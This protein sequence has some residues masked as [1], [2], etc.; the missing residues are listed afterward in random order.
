MVLEFFCPPPPINGGNG[1]GLFAL[2]AV[3]TYVTTTNIYAYSSNTVTLGSNFLTIN[4]SPSGAAGNAQLAVFCLLRGISNIYMYSSNSVSYG[5]NFSNSL[6]GTATGN[7]LL[8]I[9]LGY[10]A[11]PSAASYQI[12]TYSNNATSVTNTN[13]PYYQGTAS[14]GTS[15]FGLFNMGGWSTQN[16]YSTT[17]IYTYAT[18]AVSNGTNIFI[19]INQSNGSASGNAIMGVF[20]NGGTTNNGIWERVNFDLNIYTYSS[21]SVTNGVSL[22]S[23]ASYNAATGNDVVGIFTLG[24]SNTLTNITNTYHYSQN[25]VDIGTNITSAAYQSTATSNYNPG[26]NT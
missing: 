13:V 16:L 18:N 7:K 6:Y 17:Q 4:G 11:F 25:I 19:G 20:N 23:P 12:Y 3:P 14:A 22:S 15:T 1:F 5:N 24:F 8:G 2:G 26:V 21:N 10:S 9:Y